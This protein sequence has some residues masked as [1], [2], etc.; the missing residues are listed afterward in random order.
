M[1]G[2]TSPQA[3]E[4]NTPIMTPDDRGMGARPHG[5]EAEAEPALATICRHVGVL[6]A[7]AA[8]RLPQRLIAP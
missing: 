4:A 6:D 7:A 3:P 5:S 8:V 1:T 2:V